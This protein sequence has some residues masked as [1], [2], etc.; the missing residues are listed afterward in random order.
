MTNS[1]MVRAPTNPLLGG[2]RNAKTK[3]EQCEFCHRFGLDSDVLLRSNKGAWK[4][5]FSWSRSAAMDGRL[6]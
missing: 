3:M 1:A 5:F 6:S 4:F 2:S